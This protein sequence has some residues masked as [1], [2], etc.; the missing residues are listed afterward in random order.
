MRHSLIPKVWIVVAETLTDDGRE[1]LRFGVHAVNRDFAHYNAREIL[2][3][4]GRYRVTIKSARPKRAS[5][6]TPA[7][8]EA[9]AKVYAQGFY[10]SLAV[11]QHAHGARA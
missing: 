9:L 2:R 4:A 5:E 3:T 11:W 1:T 10:A 8:P 6:E 7:L